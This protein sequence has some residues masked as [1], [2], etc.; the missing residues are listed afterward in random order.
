MSTRKII[1]KGAPPAAMRPDNKELLGDP[2]V[3]PFVRYDHG[4]PLYPPN[5]LYECAEIVLEKL[6]TQDVKSIFDQLIERGSYGGNYG[7]LRHSTWFAVLGSFFRYRVRDEPDASNWMEFCREGLKLMMPRPHQSAW[8]DLKQF[9]TRNIDDITGWA[10]SWQRVD[11]EHL[12]IFSAPNGNYYRCDESGILIQ[13]IGTGPHTLEET[14]I[15]FATDQVL[16]S[17]GFAQQFLALFALFSITDDFKSNRSAYPPAMKAQITGMDH[18]RV[19]HGWHFTFYDRTRSFRW[20]P[21]S[22]LCD[23]YWLGSDLLASMTD[24]LQ[25]DHYRKLID[26]RTADDIWMGHPSKYQIDY[27]IDSSI[28]IGSQEEVYLDFEGLQVRWMNGTPERNAVVSILVNDTNRHDE[29]EQKF[30]R[31]LT[32]MVW[33]HK[34]PIRVLWGVRGTKKPFPVAYGPRMARGVQVDPQS[35]WNDYRK[36][37]TD[38]QWLALA[39]YREALNSESKFYAFFSYYKIFDVIFPKPKDKENWINNVAPAQTWEKK[40]VEEIRKTNPDLEAY[41]RQEQLNAIKHVMKKPSLNPDDPSH[42]RSIASDLPLI[43]DLARLAIETK[44]R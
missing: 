11:S 27:V 36:P 43:K 41:L 39:L 42:Q 13:I 35:A 20:R 44:L 33:E 30:N 23:P 15:D 16:R 19:G 29:E 12:K 17:Y 2:E 40:R 21:N 18:G 14:R 22:N 4:T 28:Q 8:S 37:K 26:S 31:L 9:I 10:K 1:R 5:S 7:V 32:A 3:T 34:H 25:V 38:P 6:K 24:T